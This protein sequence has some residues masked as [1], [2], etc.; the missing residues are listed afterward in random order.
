RVD[1]DS[2][3]LVDVSVQIADTH[4]SEA[5][6][7]ARRLIELRIDVHYAFLID[8]PPPSVHRDGRETIAKRPGA[9]I[10]GIDRHLTAL[11]H[12]AQFARHTDERMAIGRE[13]IGQIELRSDRQF[14]RGVDIAP[15]LTDLDRGEVAGELARIVE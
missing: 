14:A 7:E 10:D 6:R 5:F 13:R 1:F 9:L 2:A 12:E 3:G 15:L 4:G 11:G 8:I